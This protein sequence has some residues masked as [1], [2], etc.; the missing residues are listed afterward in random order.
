MTA[1]TTMIKVRDERWTVPRGFGREYMRHAELESKPDA[2]RVLV[3]LLALVGYGATEQQIAGWS[4]RRRVEASVYAANV[5]CRAADN[6]IQRHPS[7]AWLPQPWKGPWAGE[8]AFAGPTP[9][10]IP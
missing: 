2:A 6:P 1:A 3:D 8:G 10:A 4:V 7:L 5:H 9:T